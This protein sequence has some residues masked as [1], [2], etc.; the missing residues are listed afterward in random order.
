[1]VFGMTIRCHSADRTERKCQ[2]AGTP[3]GEYF[4][5]GNGLKEIPR[6]LVA[7]EEGYDP[8]TVSS[9]KT[10]VSAVVGHAWRWGPEQVR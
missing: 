6:R 10:L 5:N 9:W 1:M 7:L 3:K 4:F 2:L 8:G